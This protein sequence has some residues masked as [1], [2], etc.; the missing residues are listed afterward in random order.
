MILSAS[1]VYMA[2]DSMVN[3][4]EEKLQS[5]GNKKS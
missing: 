1:D 5:T 3:I 4:W 2:C